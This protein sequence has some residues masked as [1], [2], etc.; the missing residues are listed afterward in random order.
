[1]FSYVSA[2]LPLH[3]I[4]SSLMVSFKCNKDQLSLR[5]NL[6]RPIIFDLRATNKQTL[7]K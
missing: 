2:V 1:L 4:I 3:M 6:M 5:S 7:H